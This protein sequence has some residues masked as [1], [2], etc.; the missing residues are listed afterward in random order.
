MKYFLT[1]TLVLLFNSTDGQFFSGIR[2]QAQYNQEY[3]LNGY[4]QVRELDVAGDKLNLRSLGMNHY[5]VLQLLIEKKLK[6]NG[7]VTLV[8]DNF[9]VTG[10]SKLN[11][12]IAFNGTLI[13]AEKGV[14]VSPTRYFRLTAYY[15]NY[16]W[17]NSTIEFKYLL[18]VTYDHATFYVDGIVLPESPRNEVYESFGKQ[19]LPYPGGGINVLYTPDKNNSFQIDISGTYI[20]K[21]KS[22]FNEGGPMYLH[23]STFLSDFQYKRNINFCFIGMGI[24]YRYM[25]L[26][27]ESDEDTND[28]KYQVGSVFITVGKDF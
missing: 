7:R 15:Q 6:R 23:Y 13:D 4:V 18:G 2:L 26:F 1:F 20:P 24:K 16:F 17:K 27:Q 9:I 10:N 19:A 12:S 14:D 3:I 8:Y 5:P 21:F 25:H 28:L 22:F 11:N